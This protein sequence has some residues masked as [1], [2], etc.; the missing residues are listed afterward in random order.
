MT[1]ARTLSPPIFH[2]PRAL[3]ND[4]VFL[5]WP[6]G[7]EGIYCDAYRIAE[8]MR[9]DEPAHFEALA[10]IAWTFNNRHRF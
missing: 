6:V 8:D 1:A 4:A 10:S 5:D 3:A 7:S 9:L 2:G